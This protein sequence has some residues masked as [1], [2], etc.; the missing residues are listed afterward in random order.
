VGA[1]FLDPA[2]GHIQTIWPAIAC[3]LHLKRA[4]SKAFDRLRVDT[5]DGDFVDFDWCWSERADSPTLVLFHGLEGGSAG[6]YATALA[7][8]AHRRGWNFV[9]PHFRGCSGEMNR[10][11]RAYHA[12]D[13]HEIDWMLTQVRLQRPTSP[14]YAVGVSL[15]GNA[16]CCW[17][18]EKGCAAQ[19]MV[20]SVACVSA[21]ID[22]AACG[23]AIDK[24]LNRLIY[25]RM[26]LR[27]MKQKARLKWQQFPGL[28]DLE[29]VMMATSIRAFDNAFT[30]PLHGFGSVE[31]YWQT[32]SATQFISEI[33]LRC[34]FIT[35]RNDP[36][37]PISALEEANRAHEGADKIE[38]RMPGFGGHVGF[39]DRF[40]DALC[41]WLATN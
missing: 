7:K 39:D 14:V 15:G 40:F 22:L 34:L 12:G 38:F 8:A 25:G 23:D 26:F 24:G 33:K 21:P 19:S 5:P 32:A 10:S 9:V 3:R 28:F 20:D 41:D 31:C 16:L 2:F 37:V 30:A 4:W 17:A 1:R 36:L 35:A 29:Q 27:T 6:H 13:Y 18:G 11:P